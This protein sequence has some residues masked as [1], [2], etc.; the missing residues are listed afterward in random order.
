MQITRNQEV[1]LLPNRYQQLS[2]SLLSYVI[3]TDT[4]KFFI[5]GKDNDC[6]WN[7]LRFRIVVIVVL[8]CFMKIVVTGSLIDIFCLDLCGE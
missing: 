4:Q 2:T 3:Q 7:I 1:D 8:V 5:F 6:F